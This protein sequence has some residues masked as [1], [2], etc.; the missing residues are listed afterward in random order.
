MYF[1][2]SFPLFFPLQKSV[3]WV[4]YRSYIFAASFY[5]W[6]IVL[7]LNSCNGKATSNNPVKDS[8]I[9]SGM[10]YL[11]CF[12]LPSGKWTPP[13][14]LPWSQ[15]VPSLE[16]RLFTDK[17]E[18]F[19]TQKNSRLSIQT[20]RAI[21]PPYMVSNCLVWPMT[22]VDFH[23]GFL[24]MRCWFVFC[25]HRTCSFVEGN[26]FDL[27]I[28]LFSSCLWLISGFVRREN[29]G[30]APARTW[31]TLKRPMAWKSFVK[32]TRISS[33]A[34]RVKQGSER[35]TRCKFLWCRFTGLKIRLSDFLFTLLIFSRLRPACAIVMNVERTPAVFTRAFSASILVAIP[36]TGTFIITHNQLDTL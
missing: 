34:V 28:W 21:W 8:T 7:V 33:A 23:S 5:Y 9:T 22:F 35:Y 13:V 12:F 24:H 11:E 6:P 18:T 16:F 26:V 27:S 10:E 32:F 15:G 4:C 29:A 3:D 1:F 30:C 25:A 2:S 17:K 14:H 19:Q 31:K 36:E 20:S